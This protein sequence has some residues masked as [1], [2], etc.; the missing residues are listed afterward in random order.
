VFVVTLEAVEDAAQGP[1]TVLAFALGANGAEAE[2][3]AAWAVGRDGFTQIQV[4][5]SG[6]VTNPGD[7]PED[8]REALA[9]ARRYGCWLIIYDAP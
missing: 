8:F 3:V 1:L 6:E 7:L 9:N 2:A 5:R 4:L